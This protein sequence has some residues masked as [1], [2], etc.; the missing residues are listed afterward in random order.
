MEI[1]VRKDLSAIAKRLME[2][3]EQ[4]PPE[5]LPPDDRECVAIIWE[6]GAVQKG[7]TTIEE[8]LGDRGLKARLL[9]DF[10]CEA[11]DHRLTLAI[12][13]FK[14]SGRRPSGLKP[15]PAKLGRNEICL[16]DTGNKCKNC[17]FK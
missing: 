17:Y 7:Y 11:A 15:S 13:A 6:H 4:V 10:D 1:E 8:I 12:A 14:T 3:L 9:D 16:C 5:V 2:E